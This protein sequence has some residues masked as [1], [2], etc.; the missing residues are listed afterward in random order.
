MSYCL[1]QDLP[2]GSSQP[3]KHLQKLLRLPEFEWLRDAE[4]RIEFLMRGHEEVRGGRVVLGSIHQPMVQGQLKDVFVWMLERLFG[5][6]PELLIVLD[7]EY[8]MDADERLREVLVYHELCHA[9]HAQDK[10]GTP[11]FDKEGRPVIK[12][13]G[14]DVEE[15]AAVVRRYGAY[16]PEI[17]DF[18]NAAS[19]G[20]EAARAAQG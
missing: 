10:F 20:D 4:V 3:A 1:P 9:A 14:H 2:E 5:E 11:R 13:V 15:F 7:T 17:R 16:S 6:L 12:L 19:E 8:W 18:I